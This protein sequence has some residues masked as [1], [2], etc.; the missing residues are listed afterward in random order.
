ML[1][2]DSPTLVHPDLINAAEVHTEAMPVPDRYGTYWMPA[3]QKPVLSR[4]FATAAG[5]MTLVQDRQ[6]LIEAAR[7]DHMPDYDRASGFAPWGDVVRDMTHDAKSLLFLPLIVIAGLLV[8]MWIFAV[9]GPETT[10]Y[11]IVPRTTPSSSQHARISHVPAQPSQRHRKTPE[12]EPSP[13]GTKTHVTPVQPAPTH[14]GAPVPDPRPTPRHTYTFTPDPKPTKTIEPTHTQEPTP[15]PT[16]TRTPDP[17]PTAEPTTRTEEPT[18]TQEPT[19]TSV[20]EPVPPV[21]SESPGS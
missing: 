20:T 9:N 14:S 18:H 3:T 2:A 13:T 15:E 8:M 19:K 21:I 17:E 12:P 6:A 5:A 16:T 4:D 10:S 1:R 11:T 7:E